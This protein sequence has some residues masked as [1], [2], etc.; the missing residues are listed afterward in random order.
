MKRLLVLLFLAVSVG[1]LTAP[2][3]RMF[4]VVGGGI[5]TTLFVV[6]WANSTAGLDV[7]QLT[8]QLHNLETKP[9]IFFVDLM[10]QNND[11]K[12]TFNASLLELIEYVTPNNTAYQGNQQILQHWPPDGEFVTWDVWTDNKPVAPVHSFSANST[13]PDGKALTVSLAWADK[14]VTYNNMKLGPNHF[15]LNIDISFHFMA[16]NNSKLALHYKIASSGSLVHSTVTS[17]IS[18]RMLTL[19]TVAPFE[20]FSWTGETGISKTTTATNATVGAYTP[21]TSVNST[22]DLYFSFL[23]PS[24]LMYPTLFNW[25]SPQIGLEYSTPFCMGSLCGGGAIAVLVVIIF[26]GLAL[27]GILLLFIIRRR[28]GYE[29]IQ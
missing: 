7:I 11:T 28:S 16:I 14:D 12:S 26:V 24:A 4:T 15:N 6:G 22:Y 19:G 17:A 5:S 20:T 2:T 3:E 21:T 1:A 27:L 25:S 8:F 23:T 29:P 13:A 10:Q 18:S 9:Y